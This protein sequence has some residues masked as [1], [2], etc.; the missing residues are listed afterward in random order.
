MRRT[1]L[2]P[3]KLHAGARVT[4]EGRIYTVASVDEPN[5]PGAEASGALFGDSDGDP[6][7]V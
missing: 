5:A 4:L 6:T 3:S 1:K 2:P 7:V